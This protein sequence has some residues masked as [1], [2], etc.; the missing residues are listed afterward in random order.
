MQKAAMNMKKTKSRKW[1]CLTFSTF[2]ILA[3]TVPS[4]PLA[5]SQ[6][7]APSAPSEPSAPSAAASQHLQFELPLEHCTT[8]RTDKSN[9][10]ESEHW[11]QE[12]SWPLEFLLDDV[13][14]SSLSEVAE[15]LI[16][17]GFSKDNRSL[18]LI[19]K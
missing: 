9:V 18:L 16:E 12:Q 13:L 11:L 2:S 19:L 14:S 8:Q 3:P 7:S 4:A 17:V 5:P 1:R 6:P 10:N 15:R